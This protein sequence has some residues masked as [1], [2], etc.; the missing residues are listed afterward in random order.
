[1]K[2]NINIKIITPISISSIRSYGIFRY[3]HKLYTQ[4][5]AVY[6]LYMVLQMTSY[7]YE[8]AVMDNLL[9]MLSTKEYSNILTT[10]KEFNKTYDRKMERKRRSPPIKT[11]NYKENA[12]IKDYVDSR[13]SLNALHEIT[14][15][16]KLLQYF[17]YC[18]QTMDSNKLMDI[19]HEYLHSEDPLFHN[20]VR[21]ERVRL[22]FDHGCKIKP[23]RK[24]KR[25]VCMVSVP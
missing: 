14:N 9:P 12:L 1:M 7:I 20:R 21:I 2:H 8:T 3:L 11:D 6:N 18:K 17:N 4:K 5:K 24:K 10:C 22:A 15:K 23:S 16:Q 19:Y 25:R 13:G